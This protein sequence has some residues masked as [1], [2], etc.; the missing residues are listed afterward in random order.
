MPLGVPFK[1]SSGFV[2]R[3]QATKAP[4]AETTVTVRP[5][6]K[7]LRAFAPAAIKCEYKNSKIVL[8]MQDVVGDRIKLKIPDAKRFAAWIL[9]V[10]SKRKGS[11]KKT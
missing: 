8:Y 10:T 1:D 5:D 9:E 4:K 2:G 7:S 6:A 3:S 11:G